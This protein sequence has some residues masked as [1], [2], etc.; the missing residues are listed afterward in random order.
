MRRVVQLCLMLWVSGACAQQLKVG[1]PAVPIDAAGRAAVVHALGQAMQKQYVFP[2]IG[3]RVAQE[4]KARGAHGAYDS[5]KTVKAFGDALSR[6]VRK[7]ADDRHLR[8][9]FYPDF[10]KGAGRLTT[11]S[12]EVRGKWVARHGYGITRVERLPG[13][14]GLLRVDGFP[15]ADLMADAYGSAMRLLSGTDAL[16]VDLRQNGGGG[17]EA[18][19]YLMSYFFDVDDGRR[20]F[21]IYNHDD[22]TTRQYWNFPVSGPRY[23]RPVYVLVSARTMSAGES[24]AYFMQ[25]RK[26]ATVVGDVT[27]GGANPG[28]P[29]K[30]G[31]G[32]VAFVPIMRA[33]DPQTGKNWEHVGVKPDVPADPAKAENVAYVAALKGLLP[34]VR[35]EDRDAVKAALAA[36][37]KGQSAPVDYSRLPE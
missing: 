19:A 32:L 28:R 7:L 9:D 6:D 26:R 20:L 31:H 30:L 27:W 4:L 37:E 15:D 11:P 12:A 36:A 16:I 3:Q 2:A 34:K 23:T 33:Y 1:D 35:G 18:V 21:D 25:T 13:N 22:G 29:V 17:P 10:D 5:Y 8:V 14:I 24:F